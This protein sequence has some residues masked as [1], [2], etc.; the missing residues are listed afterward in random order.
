M[1]RAVPNWLGVNKDDVQLAEGE[2]KTGADACKAWMTNQK[3]KQTH[4]PKLM[5]AKLANNYYVQ[6]LDKAME[7]G[8]RLSLQLCVPASGPRALVA[9]EERYDVDLA[10]LHESVRALSPGRTHRV[11]VASEGL[12][13]F[14]RQWGG[15]R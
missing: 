13:R 15:N 14:E 3:Q 2:E 1:C 5:Q 4:R 12:T 6:A 7:G 11:F 10:D 8:A 9:G